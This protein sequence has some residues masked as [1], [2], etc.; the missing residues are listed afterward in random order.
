[1]D[2]KPLKIKASTY[3][4]EAIAANQRNLINSAQMQNKNLN[5][6]F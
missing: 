1:L 4:K 2:K 3:G 5:V 6:K